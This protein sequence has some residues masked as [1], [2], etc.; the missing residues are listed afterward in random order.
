MSA[1]MPDSGDGLGEPK[2]SEVEVKM[3]EMINQLESLQQAS[4]KMQD[5]CVSI[6]ARIAKLYTIKG[7]SKLTT[8][9]IWTD[10]SEEQT[11]NDGNVTQQPQNS[12]NIE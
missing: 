6:Q 5:R 4:K 3:E 11:R 7:V 10:V 8:E 1:F 2:I 12:S 9:E